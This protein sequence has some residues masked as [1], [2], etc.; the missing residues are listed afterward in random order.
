[1]KGSSI[2][3][4]TE[5]YRNGIENRT[6]A[7][8]VL[9]EKSQIAPDNQPGSFDDVAY[10]SR[11]ITMA[12]GIQPLLLDGFGGRVDCKAVQDPFLGSLYSLLETFILNVTL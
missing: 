11:G 6:A 9:A 3:K 8:A 4:I 10:Q 7:E 2:L 12:E 1:V 5:R